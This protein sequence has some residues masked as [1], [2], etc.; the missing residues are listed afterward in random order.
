M[1]WIYIYVISG[2]QILDPIIRMN[3][4]HMHLTPHS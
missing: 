1:K 4:D 2:N 3:D